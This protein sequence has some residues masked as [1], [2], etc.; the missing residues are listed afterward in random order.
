MPAPAGSVM[1][2][3]AGDVHLAGVETVAELDR[4]IRLVV[5]LDA[6]QPEDR[7]TLAEQDQRGD[8]RSKQ[9]QSQDAAIFIGLGLKA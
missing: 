7:R 1:A 8:Q 2:V 4:L 5:G 6:G 9:R 3:G